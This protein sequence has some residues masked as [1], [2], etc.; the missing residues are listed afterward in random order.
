MGFVYLPYLLYDEVL[1]IGTY[2]INRLNEF[3]YACFALFYSIATI[4][5]SYSGH[6]RANSIFFAFSDQLE[7]AVESETAFYGFSLCKTNY[8][9]MKID[10]F[11]MKLW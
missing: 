7:K 9:D 2:T 3:N 1:L 5:P 10:H 6:L 4:L 8:C 11:K